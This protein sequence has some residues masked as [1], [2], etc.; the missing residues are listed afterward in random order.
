MKKF[1]KI[2][3]RTLLIILVLI[4]GAIAYVK[5]ALPNVGAAPNLTIDKTPQRVERG[6]YLANHV[7]VCMDC[8]STRDW[9]RFSGP[10]QAGSKGKGGEL[11]DQ[12]FGF[13]GSFYSSNITPAGIAGYT[14]GELFRVI[15][16]G[17]NKKGKALFPVMPYHNYGRMDEEDI[18]SIIA[19]IRT[20][21]PIQNTVPESK[22][23]FPMS[24]LIN[25][26]PSKAALT[27]I[28]SPADKV[29]YGGYLVNAAACMD[30]HTQFDKGKLVAGS[31]FG[32][33]REFPF[34]DGSI[35]RS[36]NITPHEKGIGL[37]SEDQFVNTFHSK[38]DSLTQSV[39]IKPGGFNSIMPW[40]MYAKMKEE[41]LRA[42]YA[43]LKTMKP[44]DKSWERFTVKKQ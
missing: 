33:G 29:A 17:V 25:T 9:S 12:K 30:C 18:Y 24:I 39:V 14:D 15:T 20:L 26:I 21:A 27:K 28:P 41:D 16:T 35:V 11:F 38:T 32:G 36:S 37:W 8:H 4:G 44:I 34:P 5:F 22:A 13:P 1:K 19:Y 40:T 23:D 10:M 42:I 43:Y 31:E 3:G 7:T 6:R 2:F